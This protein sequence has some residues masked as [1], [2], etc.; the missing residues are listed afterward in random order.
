MNRGGRGLKILCITIAAV[1]VVFAVFV[2]VKWQRDQS[3]QKQLDEFSFQAD[4]YKDE[5]RKLYLGDYEE[6]YENLKEEAQAIIKNKDTSQ[7]QNILARYKVLKENVK[8][9]NETTIEEELAQAKEKLEEAKGKSYINEETLKEIEQKAQV[10][11]D[12]KASGEY[13][14]AYEEVSDLI[15]KAQAAAIVYDNLQIQVAQ[16]DASDYPTIRLYID[17]RDKSTGEV[18]SNLTQNVF[19]LS[20]QEASNSE[21]IKKEIQKVAQLDQEES[22]NINMV[23]DISGSMDGGPLSSAQYV[24]SNFLENVQFG[25]GDQVELTLFSNGVYTAQ[26][27]TNDKQSIVTQINNLYTQNMTSLYDALYVAVNRTAIQNGAKCV[28]AFTDGKDNYSQCSPDQ[29]IDVAQR[30]NIPIFII[31]VGSDVETSI[32]ENIAQST[33][34]YYTHINNVGDMGQIYQAVYRTQKELYVLQY[35]ISN[36]T[37]QLVTQSIRIDIQG[38]GVGGSCLAEYSPRMLLAV[39]HTWGSGYAE[40]DLMGRYLNGFVKAINSHDYSYIADTIITGSPIYD[41]VYPYIQRDIKEKLLSYEIIDKTY[42]GDDTCVLKLHE[43]YEILNTREP[44]H[45]RTLETGYVLKKQSNG[46]WKLYAFDGEI[47]ILSK[48][49]S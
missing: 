15:I 1:F 46:Q 35:E 31:G 24:M 49:R 12:Y 10:I 8:R 30:Y 7:I 14:K 37:S 48:I 13:K 42:L 19:F 2:G 4:E 11:S 20:E 25:I 44:L 16:V 38:N 6:A 28:I 26:P 43:T 9:E 29:V 41:E 47:K 40:E 34:G 21:Y 36:A 18:P 27:F 45:M 17:V 3:T 33:N 5:L 39:D 23:A 22:L 32:L